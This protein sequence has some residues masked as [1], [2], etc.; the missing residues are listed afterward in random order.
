MVVTHSTAAHNTL[1]GFISSASAGI[2]VMS[3]GNSTA[4]HNGIGFAQFPG[5]AGIGTFETLG[6]NTVRQ[7]TTASSGLITPVPPM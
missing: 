1:A 5:V 7:N 4:A 6:N 2:A 3:V